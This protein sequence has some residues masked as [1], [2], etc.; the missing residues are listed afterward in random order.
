MS[1]DSDDGQRGFESA[2]SASPGVL[3]C[4][5]AGRLRRDENDAEDFL[6]WC[7]PVRTFE[8]DPTRANLILAGG[9]DFIRGALASFSRMQPNGENAP[10]RHMRAE[11]DRL[12]DASVLAF[13]HP[14]GFMPTPSAREL[15]RVNRRVPSVGEHVTLLM[16]TAGSVRLVS[17]TGHWVKATSQRGEVPTGSGNWR[18]ASVLAVPSIVTEAV[19]SVVEAV[20]HPNTRSG[21]EHVQV[22]DH[23]YLWTCGSWT[24]TTPIV[25]VLRRSRCRG[26]R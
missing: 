20:H 14:R 6:L 2:S 22:G 4:C 1:G 12:A 3:R 11:L 5:A 16:T 21:I 17:A 24:L 26:C 15:E 10:V 25:R 8:H 18:P 23:L 9:F 19:A 13:E 7:M